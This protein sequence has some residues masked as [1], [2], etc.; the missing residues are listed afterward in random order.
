MSEETALR[1]S[2][3]EIL[4]EVL[5]KRADLDLTDAVRTNSVVVACGGYCDVFE[6][7]WLK[8]G[9]SEPRK[10]AVKRIRIHLGE[11]NFTRY[12]A[13]EICVWSGL[14][15]P[16]ILPFC[17]YL[18]EG[19]FLS[20]ISEWMENGTVRR[21]LERRPDLDLLPLVI[22]IA[23]GLEYL[24]GEGVVHS[25]LKAENV[26]ISD[27]G[28]PRICDFGIS[29]ILI[30]SQT[31]GGTSSQNN[32]TK[33]SLR[34]MSKEL[35][36]ICE[37]PNTH[38]MESDIWAFG[39]TVYELLTKELPFFHL[40]NDAL[41]ILHIFQGNQP[42]RPASIET[43]P[44]HYQKLWDLCQTCWDIPGKRPGIEYIASTLRILQR[45]EHSG[46]PVFSNQ[47]ILA[48][49]HSNANDSSPQAAVVDRLHLMQS[50]VNQPL[51]KTLSGS[52]G[53]ENLSATH[54]GSQFVGSSRFTESGGVDPTRPGLTENTKHRFKHRAW[55][56]KLRF[57][58]VPTTGPLRS[59]FSDIKLRK[60]ERVH[61]GDKDPITSD[62]QTVHIVHDLEGAEGEIVQRPLFKKVR[63]LSDSP[64]TIDIPD[65]LKDSSQEMAGGN[66]EE[67][68]QK[69]HKE[70]TLGS[71]LD[72]ISVIRLPKLPT[73]LAS[74]TVLDAVET[75]T[76][77]ELGRQEQA[78]QALQRAVSITEALAEKD[79]DRFNPDLANLFHNMGNSLERVGRHEEASQAYQKAVSIMEALAEKGPDRFNPDLANSFYGMGINLERLGQYEEALQ[80]F[81]RTVPIR[82]ALA[83]KDPDGLNPL[84][85]DSLHCI[86]H[87]LDRL[88][89]HEE[90]FQAFQRLV[91]IREALAVKDPDRFNPVLADSFHSMG[92][93]LEQLGRYEEAL[94]ALQRAVSITEALAEKDPDIFNPYLA[95]SL[96]IMSQVLE[97]LGT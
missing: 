93:Y 45:E 50:S 55:F 35:L 15:H 68:V 75:S 76:S 31:F 16:N 53:N 62:S 25:D 65:N 39:M 96:R 71:S 57:Q 26:L 46:H 44:V 17:G 11:A 28:L 64:R 78:L 1:R 90:A 83:E 14:N 73:E 88:G 63:D 34:W 82:E 9:S 61:K 12:L 23:E 13:R 48:I 7:R 69:E 24:H 74:Q 43:R 58:G 40:K 10:V 54:L 79:L 49:P 51:D 41:V 37:P 87:C 2:P 42:L 81:Q 86:G 56:S 29:R 66:V 32:G 38:S 84:I 80:V 36:E 3:R 47:Q 94:Q 20:L 97:K 27:D 30:S 91:P 85:A 5:G 22:G 33:G 21:Y 72:H 52:R 89:R 19:N 18:L 77:S 95:E 59:W 60:D 8:Y 6:G 92:L 67:F 70:S 4:D